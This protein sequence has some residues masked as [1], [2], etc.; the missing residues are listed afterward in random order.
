[1]LAA[2]AKAAGHR[3][4]ETLVREFESGENRF[5]MRG[6]GL[7][8]AYDAGMLVGVGGVNVDPFERPLRVARVRRLFVATN[9][10]RRGVA[11]T[12]MQHIEDLACEHFPRIQLFTDSEAAHRFYVRRGYLPVTRRDRVSHE[13]LF[14]D[15]ESD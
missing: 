13:K 2:A 8:V 1:M 14:G 3:N 7:F 10:R 6:E 5:D 15:R 9:A 11:T 4:I 12:L